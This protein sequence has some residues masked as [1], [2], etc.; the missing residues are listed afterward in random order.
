M[1]PTLRERLHQAAAALEATGVEGARREAEALLER[2]LRRDRAW[3]YA[4]PEDELTAGDD[5]RWR[6]WI[7]RRAA[8][9]PAQYIAGVAEFWGR[10]FAVSPAVLIPRPETELL[11]AAVLE[12][13]AAQDAARIVDVGTGSGCIAVTLALERPR[14]WVA[15]VDRSAAALEVARGNAR[16]LGAGVEFVEGDLLEGLDGPFDVIVSNPPYVS[17]GELPGLAREVREHE[18]RAALVAGPRGDEIYRRLIP[19]ALEKL[20]PGGWLALELGYQSAAM[21]RAPLAGGGWSDVEIRRDAQAWE[22]VALA[23][24]AARKG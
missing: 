22:R 2:L 24:R 6:S 3:L 8:G 20:R 1:M 19:Q 17:D 21:V 16:R 9:E 15:G 13:I 23:R 18:P 5:A 11:V 14:A 7:A 10:A 12:R 4:H